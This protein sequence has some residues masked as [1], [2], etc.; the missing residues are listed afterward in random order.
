M[1]HENI[2]IIPLCPVSY[3]WIPT[4]FVG[5]DDAAIWSDDLELKD[6]VDPEAEHARHGAVSAAQGIAARRHGVGAAPNCQEVMFV[7]L[8]YRTWALVSV[9]AVYT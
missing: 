6:A 3:L 2:R 8:E 7:H 9:K 5:G 4:V 1:V